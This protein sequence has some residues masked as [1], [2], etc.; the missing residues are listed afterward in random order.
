MGEWF[1]LLLTGPD[2]RTPDI[3]RVLCL[4]STVVI[5]WM[6]V[7]ECVVERRPTDFA[8]LGACLMQVMG[9]TGITIKLKENSE[10]KP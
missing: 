7:W 8:L 5:L 6:A 2:N 10:P 9:A 4:L 1:R 3:A